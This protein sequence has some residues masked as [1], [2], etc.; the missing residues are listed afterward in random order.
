MARTDEELLVSG[1]AEDFGLFYDRNHEWVLGF[2]VRRLRDPELAAD[3]AAEV[4]AAALVARKR[5]SPER[6]AAAPWLYRIVLNKLND[7]LRRGYAESRARRRLQMDAVMPDAEDLRWIESLG[8]QQR[9]TSLLDSLPTDQRDAVRARVL[10][11]QDYGEIAASSGVS[12]AVVRKRVS[13]GLGSL[14]T[15]MGGRR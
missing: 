11:E 15:L 4:F 5:F 8:A 1:D 14:K 13:R 12:E 6:G 10:D 3:L 7:T 2:L 9:V